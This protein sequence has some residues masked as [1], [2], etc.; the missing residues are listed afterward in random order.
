MSL[1]HL[2]QRYDTYAHLR[3][4][5]KPL[6]TQAANCIGELGCCRIVGTRSRSHLADGAGKM[7][8][9]IAVH[10]CSRLQ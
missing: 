1:V 8:A 6:P 9:A 5:L 3:D 4:S 10:Q 7:P 2:A